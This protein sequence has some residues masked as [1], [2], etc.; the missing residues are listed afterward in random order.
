MFDGSGSGA[1]VDGR[2]SSEE[3]RSTSLPGSRTVGRSINIDSPDA[4][5][6]LAMS[7]MRNVLSAKAWGPG[8]GEDV[9]VEVR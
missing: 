9:R 2:T 7:A 8:E 1:D 4:P 3:W 5:F 6:R